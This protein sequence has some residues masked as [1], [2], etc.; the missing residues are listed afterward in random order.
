MMC[1]IS[2]GGIHLGYPFAIHRLFQD[3]FGSIKPLDANGIAT[4]SPFPHLALMQDAADTDL[5]QV[6]APEPFRGRRWKRIIFA[7]VAL[8]F[9]SLLLIAWG[10][11]NSIADRFVQSALE[12]RD[13]RATYQIDQIGFRTQR[14][15]NLVI[16]DPANPD[17]TAKQVEVDV[18]LNFSG[19]SLR[20]V[21]AQGVRLHGRYIN[22]KLTFGE[23]DKFADPES[24]EPF[25]WPDIGLE[26]KDATALIETPWGKIAAAL[27]GKGLLRNRFVADLALRS[28][29]IVA[30]GCAAPLVKFDGKLLLEWRQ[31]HLVG[32]LS[33]ASISCNPLGLAISAPAFD[34][35]VKLSEAL[36]KW[37]GTTSFAAREVRYR[38]MLLKAAS[39]RLS[40]DG[41]LSRTNFALALDSAALRSAPL[42]VPRLSLNAKGY[43]G[44][45]NAEFALSARGDLGFKGGALDRGS[46]GSIQALVAGTRTMPVGPLMAQMAPALERT[47]DR[48]DANLDFDMFRDFQGRMG[49]N[50][51]SFLLKSASGVQ[52]RQNSPLS[53][54]S[55]AAGWRIGAPVNLALSGR[56]LPS[57]TLSLRQSAGDQWSGNLV[58]APYANGQARLAVPGLA[59][60]GKPYGNWRFDGRALLSG[61]IPGGRVNGLNLPLSGR[62]DGKVFSLY[63]RCQSVRFDSLRIANFALRGQELRL[64]P[65][66]G[67][68]MLATGN[69]VTR[70]AAQMANFKASG[71]LGDAPLMVQSASIRFSLAEGFVARDVALEI[72]QADNFTKF[73]L[74][75]LTGRFDSEGISG[76]LTG[77]AGKIG[78]VPLLIDEAAGNWRYLNN[79]LTLDSGLKV[80]DAEQVDRFEPMRVPDMMLTLEN[81]IIRAIGNLVEPETSTRIA[82]LDIRHD[83]GNSNG[84]ALL[85]VDNLRFDE[86][87]QP[88]LLTPLVLGVFA[89]VD[90]IVSGDG[91]IEWDSQGVR[92][93]GNVSTDGMNL[94]AAFGPVDGLTT[95][96]VFTDLLG[97]ETGLAQIATIASV[98][99]GIPALNGTVRYQ[100]LPDQQVRIESGR[101]PFA[102]GELILEPTILDFGVE[103]ERR[104]TFRVVGV[105]AEKF[106]AGYDFQNLRV[107]GVFDGTL[108]MIFNQDGGRIVG[109]AL[110]SR[111]GGGEVSYL[112]ELA[113]KDMGTFANFA[114]NAL[115]SIRYTSLT[116]GVGGDLDGE[117][118]TD[119]SFTGLQQGSGAKQNF[120]TKQLARI[121]IKFNVSV[122]AEFLKLIGSIRGLYDP[123]YAAER[124]LK[125]L[126]DQQK[127]EA[128]IPPEQLSTRKDEQK[129]E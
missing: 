84:R 58:I 20:D 104:L 16:G 33:A 19:A 98:N 65:D 21:R 108:P 86:R 85:A 69:G 113:Y 36:N 47:G 40:V 12:S 103:K 22:G 5:P 56:A 93:S 10:Q 41:G 89:N 95:Q 90:G 73:A 83:L 62:Y 13:V 23:L 64:C 110:I 29:A 97:L 59:F 116:I 2:L 117:I 101:W 44:V 121:P 128:P 91:R 68:A 118:V 115:R 15:R 112:G 43:A 26:I 63:D 92:S 57:A 88:N 120:I 45:K 49:A 71:S 67:K 39:G 109:G 38:N 53:V 25:E 70:F 9:V 76:T 7:A 60:Y 111:P 55:S 28:S 30:S 77:G 107:T 74:A 18:A 72:G 129:D 31:P 82:G 124:D 122:K 75:A 102:G 3:F 96:M 17:L 87:F 37:V 32:P 51:A 78:A 11:R 46:L 24:T 1:V 80:L 54:Q 48:F 125:F 27:N 4:P 52:I 8:L 100:L 127:G 35:D 114:F 34:V 66:A 14:I 50:V 6:S 61:P 119:I 99:P 126:I 106:L 123:S 42:T 79:V 94:A 81:N 105:D